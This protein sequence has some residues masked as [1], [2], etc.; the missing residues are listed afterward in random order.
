MAHKKSN[1]PQPSPEDLKKR[2]EMAAQ[3][4]KKLEERVMAARERGAHV[5]TPKCPEIQAL[6][7]TTNQLNNLYAQL[8]THS[9]PFSNV[10][11]A[12]TLELE[13]R[14]ASICFAM[15]ELGQDISKTLPDPRARF[16]VPRN[17][18]A[19]YE[20]YLKSKQAAVKAKQAAEKTPVKLEPKKD[21]PAAADADENAAASA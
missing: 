2:E 5:I 20:A 12:K 13:K 1:R 9:G 7:Q 16:F 21:V 19:A 14:M 3:R 15:V 18:E 8:K 10:N 4:E 11:Q 17:M 6:I